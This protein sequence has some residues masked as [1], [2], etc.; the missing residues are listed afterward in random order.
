[1]R[2]SNKSGQE[3]GL[4][5]KYY[6]LYQNAIDGLF[7]VDHNGFIHDANKACERIT[8]YSSQELENM[9]Y[10]EL[11]SAKEKR[12]IAHHFKMIIN[13]RLIPRSDIQ[14][15]IITKDRSTKMVEL[16]IQNEFS[17]DGL[18]QASIRDITDK[19]RLEDR[20]IKAQRMECIGKL[21]NDVAHKF[22]DILT[23]ILGSASYLRAWVRG[24]EECSRYVE[25]IEKSASVG[26][27]LVSQLMVFGNRQESHSQLIDINEVIKEV[28]SLL[29]NNHLSSRIEVDSRL[30]E[31]SPL[32]VRAD[33]SQIM[34]AV[35]NICHNAKDAMPQGGKLTIVTESLALNEDFCLKHIGLRPGKY[36]H[37]QISDTGC[38]IEE[39]SLP[40]IFDPF[41]TTKDVGKGTGLGLSVAFGIIRAH[42]GTIDVK[43][44][45]GVGTSF[46]IYL[47]AASSKSAAVWARED[48]MSLGEGRV[49]VVEDEELVRRMT[50]N[51]LGRLGYR[52][53][54][55]ADGEEALELYKNNVEPID[56]VILDMIM[57]KKDGLE[58]FKELKEIDQ[59]VRVVISTG[60]LPNRISSEF[61]KGG[62]VGFIQKPYTAI[63][64]SK[65]VKRVLA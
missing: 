56:L 37:I 3:E 48:Q 49:M 55:A 15:E 44:Q 21:V 36:L 20:I 12:F 27:E 24:D 6:H 42:H 10:S 45:V 62:V 23:G 51:I 7:A 22:N 39:K 25:T 2:R 5:G 50:S 34:Q 33:K 14:I 30:Q 18:I 40:Y 65:L 29:R 11:L 16:H 52:V 63:E 4:E 38:G 35:M 28:I 31:G 17:Q 59:N 41:F 9:H 60:Y 26:A 32:A 53:L 54:C 43:S 19:K 58:T 46:D 57:P 8:G 1:M 61:L 64:L 13:E 47:P